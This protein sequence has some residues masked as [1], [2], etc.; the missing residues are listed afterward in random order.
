MKS[1]KKE[2]KKLPVKEL[3]DC[4]IIALSSWIYN[5]KCIAIFGIF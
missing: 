3:G 1:R 5:N 4:E 2:R